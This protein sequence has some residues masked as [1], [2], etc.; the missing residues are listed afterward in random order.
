MEL[1]FILIALIGFGALLAVG[2]T[3]FATLFSLV[4]TTFL[5]LLSFLASSIGLSITIILVSLYALLPL[6][7]FLLTALIFISILGFLCWYYSETKRV[8]S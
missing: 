5:A 2:F 8:N 3:A 6:N 7:T 1:F 4:M